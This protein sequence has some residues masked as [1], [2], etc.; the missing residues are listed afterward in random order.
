MAIAIFTAI[1][2]II[3]FGVGRGSIKI[4]QGGR[5]NVEVTEAGTK[6]F[7]LEVDADLDDLQNKKYV[8]FKV[9]PPQD[10]LW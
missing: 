6:R 2:F 7:S 5:I 10:A 3:G 4:T 1:A 8:I 9:V